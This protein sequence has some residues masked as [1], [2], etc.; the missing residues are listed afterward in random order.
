MKTIYSI[1]TFLLFA[2]PNILYAQAPNWLWAR[3]TGGNAYASIANGFSVDPLGNYYVA[4]N[5]INGSMILG[6][7][8]FANN[9]SSFDLYFAKYNAIGNI[10][11]A[12]QIKANLNLRGLIASDRSGNSY[13]TGYFNSQY[14]IINSDTFNGLGVPNEGNIFITKFDPSGNS[15]W[16][17]IAASLQ[18]NAI[19]IDS[20]DNIFITGIYGGDYAVFGIDT[21]P[22]VNVSFGQATFLAKYNSHGDFIWAKDYGA[23]SFSAISVDEKGDVYV[24]GA[25]NSEDVWGTDTI[26][27]IGDENIFTGKMDSSGNPLWAKSAGGQ[28]TDYGLGIA[29][30]KT[31]NNYVTG[32]YSSPTFIFGHDTVFQHRQSFGYNIITLKYDSSGNEE[33]VK[34]PGGNYKDLDYAISADDDSNIFLTGYFDSDTL[35]FGTDT[36]ANSD[37]HWHIFVA[38]YD[39]VGNT[40]W[41]KTTGN[42]CDINPSASVFSNGSLYIAGT[43]FCGN[44]GFDSDTISDNGYQN[45]FVAKLGAFP[46]GLPTIKGPIPSVTVYPN[47]ST[48]NFYFKDLNEGD[49]I[50]IHDIL[51]QSIYATKID[52]ANYLLNLSEKSKGIYFYRI[53]AKGNFIQQ[54]KITLE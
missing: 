26:Y 17:R 4:G 6:N 44:I 32:S 14:V 8:T 10:V 36:I 19:S 24:T 21:L 22:N 39:P 18:P 33:W 49:V 51:G 41:V 30:D 31:H 45:I 13:L 40:L 3:A 12:K 1:L 54:G 52:K 7:D 5:F 37:G 38:K 11:W 27:P 2:L 42:T 47:P 43:N 25:L 46:T 23:E 9:G 34:T 53:S 48:G 15:V 50:E 28:F 35:I 20:L 16:T 29:T